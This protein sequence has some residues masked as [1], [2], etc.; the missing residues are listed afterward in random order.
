LEDSGSFG[1]GVLVVQRHRGVGLV[2][3]S[4]GGRC[5]LG[6]EDGR[7]ERQEKEG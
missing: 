7:G 6:L 3:E 4:I 1:V 5:G 2:L